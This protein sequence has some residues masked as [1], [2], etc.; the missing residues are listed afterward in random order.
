MLP[1]ALALEGPQRLSPAGLGGI[2]GI[3]RIAVGAALVAIFQLN[4]TWL[5]QLHCGTALGVIGATKVI[6]Q[7][8]LQYAVGHAVMSTWSGVGAGLV[9]AA[10]LAFAALRQR[11]PAATAYM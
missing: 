3:A 11:A 7:W 9:L 4:W 6:P 1:F 8:C 2:A 10:S 5:S